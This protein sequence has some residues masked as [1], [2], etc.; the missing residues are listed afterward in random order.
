MNKAIMTMM[1]GMAAAGMRSD[2]CPR[3]SYDDNSSGNKRACPEKKE[4][5]KA[6]RKN[7]RG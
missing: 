7:R 4:K 6:R 5:K 1:I 2:S 3:L